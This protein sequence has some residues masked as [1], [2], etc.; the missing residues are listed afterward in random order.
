LLYVRRRELARAETLFRA[1]I[2]ANP[3]LA[4]V[5]GN[6]GADLLSQGRIAEATTFADDVQR[7]FP[8]G[9]LVLQARFYINYSAGRVDESTKLADSARSTSIPLL[10]LWGAQRTRE[11]ALLH[12]QLRRA[13]QFDHVASAIDSEVGIRQLPGK[14]GFDSALV[15]VWVFGPSNSMVRLIDSLTPLL[16]TQRPPAD[17]RYYDIATAYALAGQPAKA[18]TVLARMRSETK[19]TSLLRLW[20]PDVDEAMGEI[21]LA[22]HR[23]A[24][25]VTA[26][27]SADRLPDGPAAADPRW[28]QFK[29]GRAFDVANQA[30][31]AITYFERYLALPF[32]DKLLDDAFALAGVYKRLAE[33]YEAKGDR[34][35]AETNLM[36]F[37]NLWDKAD[38]ELQPKVQEAKQRLARLRDRE[39]R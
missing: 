17:R 26:F 12:G 23:G 14:S 31:S 33:L 34:T 32:S 2:R 3:D 10:R 24:D 11:L 7:R 35:R 21:A 18:R 22:E 16:T 4:I 37:I 27:R 25:A 1:S 29:I 8:N 15:T 36:R 5:Y 30:D 9:P 28:M 19:D 39:G 20:R 13:Y 38:P 6:L